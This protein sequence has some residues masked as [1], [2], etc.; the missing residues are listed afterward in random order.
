MSVLKQENNILQ[1][2]V[3][4]LVA[5]LEKER[6][7]LREVLEQAKK[8]VDQVK[9]EKKEVEQKLEVVIRE[10]HQCPGIIERHVM[11]CQRIEVTLCLCLCLPPSPLTAKNADHPLY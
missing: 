6:G 3:E 10:H 8:A 7:Q 1:A 9:T 4:K 11:T 2:K 5:V